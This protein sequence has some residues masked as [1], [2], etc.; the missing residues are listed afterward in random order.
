MGAKR[1]EAVERAMSILLAFTAREPRLSLA[2]LARE[3]G[4]HKSTILRL[5]ES[6]S[7]YGFLSRGDDGRFALGASIWRLGLI[8]SQ[9]FRQS[10]E[11]RP[12]LRDLVAATGETAS[13]YVRAAGERVCLFRENSPNLVRFH[14]EEGMRMD[15]K[16]GASG[17]V[18][19]HAAGEAVEDAGLLNA[20]G[21]AMVLG[22]RNPG[23]A[24]VATPVISKGGNLLGALSVSGPIGRFD[25]AACRAAIPL[26]EDMAL[27]LGDRL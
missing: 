8:F 27:R 19:R 16:T 6:L 21:S 9:D 23:I 15:L 13:F 4:L 18:L 14:A 1:T 11:I 26:L 10:D 24:S 3:T 22:L 20:N 7:I 5:C 2:E 12:V 25:E 17:I